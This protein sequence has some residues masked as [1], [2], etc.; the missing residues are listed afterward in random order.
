MALTNFVSFSTDVL[1]A[2]V[3]FV[4][5]GNVVAGGAVGASEDAN[6]EGI[7]VDTIG[8]TFVEVVAMSF[9]FN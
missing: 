4:V 3:D 2:D 5:T 9:C 6:V 1:A 7:A 8:M